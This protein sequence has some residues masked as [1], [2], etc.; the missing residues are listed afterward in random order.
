MRSVTTTNI[1]KQES[2]A[3][4]IRSAVWEPGSSTEHE[5]GELHGESEIRAHT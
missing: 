5:A 4:R 1:N 3:R 2:R